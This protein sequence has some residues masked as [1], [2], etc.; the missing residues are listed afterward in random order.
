[1]RLAVLGLLAQAIL[2]G[3]SDSFIRSSWQILNAD[4]FLLATDPSTGNIVVAGRTNEPFRI[5]SSAFQVRPGG[6]DCQGRV[7]H[8][9]VIAKIRP[10]DGQIVS[11][12]LL[13]GVLDDSPTALVVDQV[14]SVY[15]AGTTSSRNFPAPVGAFKRTTTSASTGFVT[16]LNPAL[17]DI[18]FSTYLG[19]RG[20]DRISAMAVDPQ[21]F[22]YLAGTTESSDFPIVE[23]AFQK[24]HAS[25]MIFVTKLNSGGSALVASTFLGIGSVANI[26]VE[27][28]GNVIVTGTTSSDRFPVT[29]DAFQPRK[30]TSA[31]THS[32]GFVTRMPPNLNSLVYST[33]FGGS[34]NDVIADSKVDAD[35]SVY[36]AGTSF[37]RDLPLTI[38]D[39]AIGTAGTAFVAKFSLPRVVYARAL[40][41]NNSTTALGIDLAP[42]NAAGVIGFSTGTHFPTTPQAYRRCTPA[43]STGGPA[44]FYTRL[45]SEGRFVYSTLLGSSLYESRQLTATTG[46]SELFLLS[47]I[48]P[49]QGTP[50]V[51]PGLPANVVQR[52]DLTP[53]SGARVDCIVNAST[54]T[55]SVV[56]AG[57]VVTIFGS[58][59]ASGTGAAG[60][61]ENGRVTTSAGGVRVLFDGVAAP[62]LY[63]SQDQVNVI[64]PFSVADHTMTQIRVEYAGAAIGSVTLPVRPT[65]PGIFRIG[66]T[67][68][69]V[70]L[71]EDGTLNAPD[72]PAARGSLITFWITGFGQYE[73]AATDGVI[74]S[75]L[76]RVR[77]PVAVTFQNQPAELLYAG[78]A[79]GMVAGVAQVNA[80]VPMTAP[81]SVRVPLSLTIGSDVSQNGA[82]LSLR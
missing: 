3:Q 65:Q 16:K 10:S 44:V 38:P 25:G 7:C 35:G 2:F 81:A 75:D 23:P 58:G 70:I 43:T 41:G 56:S 57:L 21:G 59:M 22:V 31:F 48:P 69:A 5:P 6:G 30:P 9:V 15:V 60:S 45:D 47:F 4:L 71:N 79:P 82:Y 68:Q 54:Y 18:D 61:I 74:T 26:G 29:P 34:Q 32:D 80:R 55:P 67:E 17:T 1:M 51:L 24:T 19:G 52:V 33:L 77:L 72:N 20:N 28:R 36:I 27:P 64:V 53:A 76:S 39:P 40:R 73:A 14:G 13:G 66:S 8:D 49:P 37:S 78:S 11:A 12:T 42:G 63:S 62:I 46:V 50:F